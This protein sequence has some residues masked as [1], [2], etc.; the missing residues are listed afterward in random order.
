MDAFI[1]RGALYCEECTAALKA[2]LPTPAGAD[3]ADESTFDSDRYPKGP[4]A[5]GGGEADSPQHCDSCGCFLENPLTGD[6]E[7][8]VRRA[9][10]P[11]AMDNPD[12]ETLA[13]RLESA[14]YW[15][16]AQWARHYWQDIR[17]PVKEES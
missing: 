13:A 4:F 16:K 5:D 11:Q 12:S 8:Y 1:Y 6:G 17:P 3:L 15:G 14:G 9:F 10:D 2:R 7:S